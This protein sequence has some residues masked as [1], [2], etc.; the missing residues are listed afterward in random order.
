VVILHPLA[1]EI[2]N[3]DS[4]VAEIG[5]LSAKVTFPKS[6]HRSL[7]ARSCAPRGLLQKKAQFRA[8]RGL[9]DSAGC[10][11]LPQAYL[12]DT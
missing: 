2:P 11:T 3:I 8:L 7:P 4:A 6:N 1:G 12:A 9:L 10:A 5:T